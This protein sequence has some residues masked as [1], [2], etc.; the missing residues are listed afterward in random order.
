M[1]RRVLLA[2]A[3]FAAA[4]AVGQVYSLGGTPAPGFKTGAPL[5]DLDT[6]IW[7]DQLDTSHWWVGLN[8]SFA[9]A[10][11][12]TPDRYPCEVVGARAEVN[13]G[14]YAASYFL[15]VYAPNG[16]GGAPGTI[17][18][19]TPRTDL[20]LN[21]TPGFRDYDLSTPVT[22][23]SGDFFL[24][25]I[26]T[27]IGDLYFT[28]DLSLNYGPRQWWLLG[29]GRGWVLA[30]GYNGRD[31]HL[32]ARVRYVDP[33]DVG[34]TR[35]LAPSG[36]VDSAATLTPA[37]SV[38]NY[39]SAAQSYRVRL[40]IGSAYD[41]TARVTA[42]GPGTA[43]YVQFP[44]WTT[45]GRGDYAVTCSTELAGDAVPANDRQTGSVTVRVADVAAGP[46]LEPT[47]TVVTGT[48]VTPRVR[49]R[50]LGT[51]AATLSLRCVV[52]GAGGPVYDT[53]ETGIVLASGDSVDHAFAL[54]WTAQPPGDYA[55]SAI[56]ALPGDVV[57]A[58]D[59]AFG[60]CTVEDTALP[61]G[62][63]EVAQV[64]LS[65]SGRAVKDGGSIAWDAALGRFFVLKG[66]KTADCYTWEPATGTWT[67]LPPL[68]LGVENKG[69]Y[70]GAA[71]CPDGN[72]AV[73]LT[74]GNN[75][76]AFWKYS[77]SGWTQLA[78]VPLGLS[79]KKVKG[80]TDM[81]YVAGDTD[82]VYLLK[83]YKT[84]FYRYNVTSG[85]WQTLADAPAGAKPKW[86]KGSWLA[87]VYSGGWGI[88]AHKAKYLEMYRYDAAT[89]TW[90]PL[91]A[92]MPLL[93][94]QTG[95]TRKAKDGSSGA[96][97]A[98]LGGIF[99]LKGANS[100]DFY[101]YDLDA[102]TWAEKETMPTVGS[103]AKKKRVKG[104]GDI[105][106]DGNAFY[107]LKG[108]KTLEL[109]RYVPGGAGKTPNSNA[110]V[111]RPGVQGEGSSQIADCGLQVVQNPSRGGATVCWSAPA[112]LA[113]CSSTLSLYDA[114]G[115]LVL[116][117]A[118]DNRHSS[119]DIAL[120]P[121][122][123][124]LRVSGGITATRKLVIE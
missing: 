41:D 104:G 9:C 108:N 107:A 93:C 91:L 40:R 13:R 21:R 54:G 81:V 76:S 33:A 11:R 12:F 18:Q 105:A 46:V 118:I 99:A 58:N 89:G 55:V 16:T 1:Y 45:L 50:N 64:P 75:T 62:W 52:S 20:P 103:T 56:A 102:A 35:I 109:W 96:Y 80:G 36:T 31:M 43:A 110:Q 14:T 47:D 7:Y 42:H 121:G 69:P 65:P 122:V 63:V 22:I 66:Y 4:L 49:V 2:V 116:V 72:G 114:S 19:S 90:G 79:N 77:D 26:R 28:D 94:A 84:E 101:F 119:F 10:V 5:V 97:S 123:Y 86:D 98:A 85:Q 68:P 78:D 73:Y 115:R 59:T 23:T 87:G 24:C 67:T 8:E 100:P 95:K 39:G 34:V 15:R 74:K 82:Y 48:P 25:F 120:S 53:T 17:L 83:G 88:Y 44:A 30:G 113:P 112:T 27:T 37:C 124:L 70:K 71:L 6:L 111:P 38:Y 106:T 60:A 61:P 29:D 92:G 117:R 57:P 32:R 3:V 51:Q